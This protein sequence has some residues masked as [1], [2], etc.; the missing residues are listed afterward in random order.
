MLIFD[1]VQCGVGRTGEPFAPTLRRDARHDHDCQGAGKGFPC[2]AVMMSAQVAAAVKLDAL[3]TTF[4]GGPMACAAI[5]AVIEA[6]ESERLLERVRRYR[7]Q[8]RNCIVGPVTATRAPASSSACAPRGRRR[9]CSGAARARHPR[10]HQRRSAHPAPAAA[11]HP[12]GGARGP[13]AR[14]ARGPAALK[15]FLDLADSR[16]RTSPRCSSSAAPEWSTRAAGAT[17]KV[18]GLLFFNPSL[19]TLA[20]FQAAMARLG[21]TSFVIT[22]GQGTW[23]LETSHGVVMD[24]A[25][26]EHMREGLPVLASYCDALGIRAF[27]DGWICEADLAETKFSAMAR[28]STSR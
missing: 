19:R 17:G 10:R 14:C 26:A 5:E 1:E 9:R 25:A 11:V 24:G 21:G 13:A 15:R 27:A 3:G 28:S 8:A 2:A 20:S 16:A 4:G 18:L 6:I 12:R 22:P 23:Q 7:L